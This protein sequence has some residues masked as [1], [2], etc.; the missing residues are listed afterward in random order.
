[1]DFDR[2]LPNFTEFGRFFQKPMKFEWTNFV[3]STGFLNT[4]LYEQKHADFISSNA[5]ISKRTT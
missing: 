1:M 5:R 4:V 3:V 2:I